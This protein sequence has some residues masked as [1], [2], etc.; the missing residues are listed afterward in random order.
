MFTVEKFH[1][2]NKLKKGIKANILF[3]ILYKSVI[4]YCVRVR[5]CVD[6][7]IG[8]FWGPTSNITSSK[9]QFYGELDICAKDIAGIILFDIIG[10]RKSNKGESVGKFMS[11]NR[12]SY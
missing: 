11:S 1:I 3:M 10:A 12:N 6:C 5:G 7:I 4:L 9:S 2:Q 8:S